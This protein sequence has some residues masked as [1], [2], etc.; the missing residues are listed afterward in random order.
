M[1]N[2]MKIFALV[3]CM[4]FVFP[5]ALAQET[6][7]RLNGPTEQAFA[8]AFASGKLVTGE[9]TLDLD[10]DAQALGVSAEEAAMVASVLDV[11]RQSTIT[12]GAGMNGNSLRILLAGDVADAA[13]ANPVSVTALA[14]VNLDGVAV[15]SDV[16]PGK[17][18][19]M[20]WET[21]LS[22]CGVPQSDIAMI[23]S[24]R[25][26]DLEAL[27]AQVL[28]LVE[29]AVNTAA[30][31]LMPYAAT[32]G[33]FISG[34]PM[35]VRENLTEEDYPP[36][37]TEIAVTFTQQ[38]LGVLV[39]RLCDQLEQDTAAQAVI[40]SLIAQTGET[41]TAA[42]LLSE[43]RSAAADMTDTD[44]PVT[45]FL[46]MDEAGA[47]LYVEVYVFN[48]PKGQSVYGG[49]F[50]YPDAD[51]GQVLEIVSGLYDAEGNP[52]VSLYI[53]ANYWTD[54]ADEN[55][56]AA[57]FGAYAYEGETPLLEME[58]L[59]GVERAENGDPIYYPYSSYSMAIAAE[60][61]AVQIVGSGEGVQYSTTAGGEFISSASTV[62]TYVDGVA[63]SQS[64]NVEAQIDPTDDGGLTGYYNVS[65]SMPA[66]G[67]NKFDYN[68]VFSAQDIDPAASAALETV[69]LETATSDDMN[70]LMNTAMTVLTEQKLPA[71]MNVL[72]ADL[73]QSMMG[74]Q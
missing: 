73:V 64:V 68:V 66:S 62:D 57:S 53:P 35:E 23:M 61:A 21:L 46:G 9:I 59:G 67:I 38:D 14:D 41:V 12:V 8:N 65:E 45:V 4:A 50:C 3:L 29:Q 44:T 33:E 24:L 27:L 25:T 13:G 63:V 74:A 71:L 26:L 6:G 7:Y 52:T 1:K 47:P 60:G 54:A 30:Q 70:A 69:A 48:E 31:L 10:L 49:L 20:T 19:T 37:A 36:T 28:P 15:E 40:D 39:N 43:I 55:I 5:A 58:F 11:L 56:Y 16:I 2:L 32:I 22:L 72:P 42:Q 17:R 34:L 18:L 51:L